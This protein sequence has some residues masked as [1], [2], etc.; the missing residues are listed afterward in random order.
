[1]SR[2]LKVSLAALLIVAVSSVFLWH[3]SGY[4]LKLVN[5]VEPQ[6]PT[7]VQATDDAIHGQLRKLL[8]ERKHIL[9][10]ICYDAKNHVV[11][12]RMSGSEYARI[13][14]AALLAAID[15][16]L[17]GMMQPRHKVG[18]LLQKQGD[19]EIRTEVAVGQQDVVRIELLQQLPHQ[20]QLA[21]FL[22]GVR[23]HRHAAEHGGRQRQQH[24]HPGHGKP[25]P[26]FLRRLLGER[27]KRTGINHSN[28]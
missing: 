22:A 27:T 12:G 11:A 4:A 14:K 24:H 5:A 9:D 17:A 2:P 7:Q 21:G 25:D 3:N 6:T 28:D 19:R 23:P 26:F 1:M 15:L 20:R 13:K 8:L 10:T 16:C 18:V